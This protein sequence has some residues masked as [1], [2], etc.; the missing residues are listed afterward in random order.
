[1]TVG[2]VLERMTTAEILTWAKLPQIDKRHADQASLQA[3]V[4]GRA[5]G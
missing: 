4:K 5:D 3:L 1:M 2:D